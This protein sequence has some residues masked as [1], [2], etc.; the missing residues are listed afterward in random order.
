MGQSPPGATYNTVGN[1]LP[2]IQGAAEFGLVAPAPVKW[3]SEPRKVAQAGDLLFSLRAPVG[4]MNFATGP[5]AIGRGLAI[6]RGSSIEETRFIALALEGAMPRVRAESGTGMFDSITRR[7]LAAVEVSVSPVEVQRRVL[8]AVGAADE[9]LAAYRR[10]YE[11]ALNAFDALLAQTYD[12]AS[13]SSL[14]P[15]GQVATA[16]SGISWSR[17]DE[18]EPTAAGALATIGVAHVQREA[19]VLDGV[20]TTWLKP[21]PQVRRGVIDE[22][23]LLMIRTNGNPARIGNVHRTPAAAQGRALSAFLMALTPNE[24]ADRDYLLRLLQS[25]QVQHKISAATSGSTGLKNIA[26]TWVRNLELPWPSA[27]ERGALC[28]PLAA[29]ETLAAASATRVDRAEQLRA[30]LVRDLLS[31]VH[32]VPSSYDAQLTDE[33]QTEV[34]VA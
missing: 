30:A 10:H 24:T 31:Q 21:T 9:A 27:A 5:L 19:V 2:F 26:V 29:L 18:T 1:G 13:A 8:D 4:R 17:D 23:S 22:H 32:E 12:L 28:R 3:C 25:P 7:G 16:R 14:L 34:G 15:L 20:D 11:A 33:L 6:I